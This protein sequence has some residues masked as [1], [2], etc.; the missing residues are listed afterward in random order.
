M[1]IHAYPGPAMPA[2]ESR[3]AAV[4][5]EFGGLGLGVDGHTWTEKAWGYQGMPDKDALTQKYVDL[6]RRTHE[7]K[8]KGLTAAIY[9]QTTDVETECNGFLTYD[10]AILKMDLKRVRDANLGIFPRPKPIAFVLP[11]A[12]VGVQDWRYTF[13]N[14]ESKWN[15]VSFD[16]SNWRIGKG[17]FGTTTTPGAIVETEWSSANIWIRREF[18]APAKLPKNL[19]LSMHHDEAVDVYINGVLACKAE[20]WT[21]EYE[22]FAISKEALATIKPGKNTIAAHCRQTSGGQYLDIGIVGDK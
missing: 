6:L 18:E 2:I 4:L 16:D 7:L 10:R 19:R 9:T 22:E 5:G 11:N 13:A 1:D 3:R 15:A 17:G 8:S 14:A 12:M 21:T 20:G